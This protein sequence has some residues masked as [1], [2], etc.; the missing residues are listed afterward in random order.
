M[1]EES[2]KISLELGNTSMEKSL[3]IYYLDMRPALVHYIP[4]NIWGGKFDDN[5]V[6]MVVDAN[7]DFY[8]SPVNICQ[9]SFMLL[10]D[11]IENEN[12]SQVTILKSCINKLDEGKIETNDYIYWENTKPNKRYDISTPWVSAM[13]QGQCLSFFL[14]YYQI[15]GESYYL[16]K[17]HKIFKYFNVSVKDGG[18]K[19]VDSKG[20]LW[21]EEYPSTPSS[22]VLNGFI[23]A[24]YGLYDYFRITKNK[25][26]KIFI[27]ESNKT[28]IDNIHKYDCFYWSK[29][30]LL[31]KEL[32]RYYY[33]K[34]VHV[35][36]LK[37]LYLLTGNEIFNFYS[38][39]W[40]KNVNSFNFFFVQIM[41][42]IKPRFDK[43]IK[44]VTKN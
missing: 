18:F 1:K 17:A 31:K 10:A 12:K 23:Y 33:Q 37:S 39:K 2:K 40:E 34:N 35:P 28:L 7:N 8:Y 3:G 36:Q 30:D 26:A 43:L 20:F 16:K 44:K 25:T 9:Y 29:Y 38:L 42:R 15:T 19:K 27:D 11:Y 21:F 41:Y 24:L 5:G 4:N 13:D 22:Y 32:V 14:R 6:P